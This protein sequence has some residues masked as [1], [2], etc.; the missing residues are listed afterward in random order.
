MTK[1]GHE[2]KDILSV[3]DKG[4][5]INNVPV[6]DIRIIPLKFKGAGIL[7]YLVTNERGPDGQGRQVDIG[8]KQLLEALY[9]FERKV[10]DHGIKQQ[11]PSIILT[12]KDRG[13]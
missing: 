9:T 5:Y 6:V 11:R 13:V 4:M 8:F 1:E 7:C 12:D 10:F 2:R 3:T